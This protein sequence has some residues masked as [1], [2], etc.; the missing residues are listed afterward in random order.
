M[1]FD[2]GVYRVSV[3]FGEE[4]ESGRYCGNIVAV[5]ERSAGA[6][7]RYSVRLADHLLN[8]LGSISSICHYKRIRSTHNSLISALTSLIATPPILALLGE[9]RTVHANLPAI[10]SPNTVTTH[11]ERNDLVSETDSQDLDMLSL[12]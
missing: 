10:F 5:L 1:K 4:L 9:I 8:V 7:G 2:H 3:R 12:R 6:S 11:G